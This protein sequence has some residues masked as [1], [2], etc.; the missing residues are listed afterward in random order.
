M[1]QLSHLITYLQA[2]LTF[3]IVHR[4]GVRL[5]YDHFTERL[6]ILFSHSEEKSVGLAT[7]LS[8]QSAL[9][10]RF[11]ISVLTPVSTSSTSARTMIC[12]LASPFGPS[13][14][15]V[16]CTILDDSLRTAPIGTG[17]LKVIWSSD[18]K[19][20]GF[21]AKMAAFV[22]HN[23]LPGQYSKRTRFTGRFTYKACVQSA[24]SQRRNTFPTYHT[25]QDTSKDLP[26]EVPILWEHELHR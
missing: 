4:L 8:H 25:H 5:G 7:Q 3:E 1:V 18:R 26:V 23:S 6:V 24:R 16:V 2:A 20:S 15:C 10:F 13:C 14:G 11:V 21:E 19:R 17:S 22:K 9:V 12:T